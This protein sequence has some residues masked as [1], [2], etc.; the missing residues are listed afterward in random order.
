MRPM[1][2][3][4]A[5]ASSRLSYG[6]GAFR[7]V[8]ADDAKQ[9]AA[10]GPWLTRGATRET[11][12][13]DAHVDLRMQPLKATIAAERRLFSIL[14]GTM[15]GGRLGIAAARELAAGGRGRPDRLR[16]GSRHCAR[17]TLP[18]RMPAPRRR[19]RCGS[20]G[21][22]R[23]SGGW[24]TANADRN[25]PPPAAFWQMPGDADFAVFDRGIDPGALARGRE[26]VA[27][28]RGGHA[29]RGRA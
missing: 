16:D 23:C 4:R 11:S 26:L 6:D 9:L 19:S 3:T 1:T 24:L 14:L 12:T 10:L 2:T 27:Q 20:P 5:P 22:R 8:C 17:S 21:P 13:Y 18:F 15:L 7:L 28:G 25:G 29:R